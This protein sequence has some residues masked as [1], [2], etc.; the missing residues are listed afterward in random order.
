MDTIQPYS[1]TFVPPTRERSN[2]LRLSAER[3]PG[4]QLSAC[5]A[6]FLVLVSPLGLCCERACGVRAED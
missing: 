4:Q 5:R 1:A 2:W 3:G 6:V